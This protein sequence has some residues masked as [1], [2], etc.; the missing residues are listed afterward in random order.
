MRHVF[1]LKTPSAADFGKAQVAVVAEDHVRDGER[2]VEEYF[3]TILCRRQFA[4]LGGALD[5]VE[6]LRVEGVAV[7]DQQIL[8]AVEIHVEKGCPPGPLCGSDAAEVGGVHVAVVAAVHEEC[9]AVDDRPV[10]ELVDRFG[11]RIGHDDLHH[12]EH[13]RWTHHVGDEKVVVPVAV[14]VCE[15]HRHRKVAAVAHRQLVDKLE[16]SAALIDPKPIRSLE[17]V[18]N[19]DVRPAVLVHVADH[20]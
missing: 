4:E 14:D 8:E 5:G 12:L 16:F 9:V 11:E 13:V 18:A 15:V 7:G 17:I 10:D 20:R 3:F 6:I 1:R 2:R 19:V